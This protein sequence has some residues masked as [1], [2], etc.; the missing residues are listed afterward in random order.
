VDSAVDVVVY[1][2]MSAPRAGLMLTALPLVV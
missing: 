1:M 2:P